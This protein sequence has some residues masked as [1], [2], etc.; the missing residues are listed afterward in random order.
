MDEV[1]V[2]FLPDPEK[3]N[4]GQMSFG[5]TNSN[6]EFSELQYSGSPK[7]KGVAKGW[8]RVLLFDAKSINSRDE[9][10][11]PDSLMSL[12]LLQQRQFGSKSTAIK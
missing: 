11:P 5:D 9:N 2:Q 6:G 3:E 1:H 12:R 7:L 4:A 10:I 8:V